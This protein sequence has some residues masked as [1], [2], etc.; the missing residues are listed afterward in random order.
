MT[1]NDNLEIIKLIDVYGELLT[2]K[3]Y[4]IITDY[5]FDNL[6]LGVARGRINMGFTHYNI[7]GNICACM[8]LLSVLMCATYEK[9][10]GCIF[11]N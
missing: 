5:Y 9:K 3:Q 7:L 1:I 6:F 2:D 11:S 10:N 8:L 4:S